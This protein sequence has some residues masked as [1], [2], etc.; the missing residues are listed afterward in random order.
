MKTKQIFWGVFFLAIGILLM[1]DNFS[2]NGLELSGLHQFWPIILVLIGITI[3]VKDT[4]IK[5][6]VS[7][8]NGLVLALVIYSL[9]LAPFWFFKDNN[10]IRWHDHSDTQRIENLDTTVNKMIVNI[11]AGAG[12]FA[13]N[14]GCEDLYQFDGKGDFTF[15][16][17]REGDEFGV[18]IKMEDVNINLSE[19]E[20]VQNYFNLFLN[21]KPSYK[22]DIA[23]GAASANLNLREL[24]ISEFKLSTGA[25]AIDLA[26]GY[27]FADQYTADIEMG[28]GTVR[29]TVPKDLGVEVQFDLPLS[30]K[31]LDGFNK[32]ND[33]KYQTENYGNAPKKIII[34]VD[35]GLA[36]FKI[37]RI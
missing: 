37:D 7:G 32:L 23:I 30:A 19:K 1:I 33:E 10:T 14:G 9:C 8:L 4:K 29:V 5:A 21:N 28:V 13:V 26:L 35:G 20:K 12:S 36:S 27:P 2:T 22:F 15:N 6:V 18:D 34:K 17:N 25:S 31:K 24:K 11:G 16:K 3:M